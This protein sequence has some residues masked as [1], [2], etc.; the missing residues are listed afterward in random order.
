MMKS[1]ALK[2]A[3]LVALTVVGSLYATVSASAQSWE[4][5]CPTPPAGMN[6]I[7][8][9]APVITGTS[10]PDF[11]CAG[12]S[13]NEI[14]GKGGADII[15]AGDGDD[16]V[17]AQGGADVVYAGNGDDRIAAGGGNDMVDGGAGN[18]NIFGGDNRDT[19]L[20]QAGNDRIV[21]NDGKD[22]LNGGGGNDAIHGGFGH[23]TIEGGK[24]NDRLSGN[25]GNDKINGSLG[26]DRASGG[27]GVDSCFTSNTY[28]RC[29]E[30]PD[31]DADGFMIGSG[32]IPAG[33]IDCNDADPA[34]FP[35]A[36]EILD[37]GIDQDCDGVDK[38]NQAP[39]INNNAFLVDEN[40]SDGTPVGNTLASDTEDGTALTYAIVS[41]DVDN[42]FGIDTAGMLRV[43]RAPGTDFERLD[44]YILS[45]LVTD[46]G[47][48]T[49]TASIVV[50]VADI[51]E[52]PTAASFAVTLDEDGEYAFASSEFNFTDVDA[53]D[54]LSKVQIVSLPGAGSLELNGAAVGV[55]QDIP[56]AAIDGGNLV[57]V[58]AG[59][60]NGSPYTT[61]GFK[62]H[63]GTTYSDGASFTAS[64]TVAPVNDTPE[65]LTTG[66]VSEFIEDDGP[67][68]V[69]AGVTTSDIEDDPWDAA[70]I[71]IT[72]PL[73]GEDEVLAASP[74][75]AITADDISVV[76]GVLTISG[77]AAIADVQAVMQSVTYENSSD[78]P[79]LTDRVI[80]FVVADGDLLSP[81]ATKTVM[82][83]ETND[84]PLVA[85]SESA[86]ASYTEGDGAVVI[87]VAA[88]ID[89]PDSTFMFG[90]TV[91]ITAGAGEGD[92]LACPGCAAEGIVAG[93]GAN[94]LSLAG[95][96]TPDGYQSALQ[97]VTFESTNDNPGEDDREL[98]VTA[99]DGLLL[100]E[101]ASMTFTFAAVNDAPTAEDDAFDVDE[102]GTLGD[103]VVSNDTDPEDGTPT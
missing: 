63:D 56:V 48:L 68:I 11:I 45:V 70:I 19:L 92:E 14:I 9:D 86:L 6:V 96:A 46:S 57:F 24:G 85:L 49:D 61:I 34:I 4:T 55:N 58:P 94:K 30:T 52:A 27:S 32:V 82:I 99:N 51:N 5:S 60:G 35:G 65:V 42:I 50:T 37:D 53:G 102:G 74:S 84:A 36:V 71:T 1:R 23:D 100:S 83:T 43:A 12:P 64:I 15:Y 39:I 81:L 78:A 3:T 89:E 87:D 90:L 29:E 10:G 73:D 95:A 7:I 47:G 101:P 31:D 59:D 26:T 97:S 98:T 75:G 76:A 2:I 80:S 33:S 44:Q 17:R 91:E 20:G 54:T 18:D 93:F 22:N 16:N 88:E 62:V 79:D 28:S 40:V 72:N 69:D 38:K 21:G 13:N 66:G 67:V 77:P 8:S 41:G 25:S 103:G